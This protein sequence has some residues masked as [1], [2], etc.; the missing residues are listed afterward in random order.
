VQRGRVVVRYIQ[1]RAQW[2]EERQLRIS[3]EKKLKVRRA[4]HWPGTG[5]ALARH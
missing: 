2:A 3:T 4:R 5:P 1:V